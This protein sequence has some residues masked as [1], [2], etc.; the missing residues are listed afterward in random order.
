MKQRRFTV[1][2]L[3]CGIGG[4]DLGF[5]WAGFDVIW[6][7][8]IMPAAIDSYTANF[9]RQAVLSDINILPLDQ[10]PDADVLIGGPPCQSF[11]LVGQRR[12]GDT[13]GK[14]V[15]R[16]LEIVRIKRPQAFVMENVPGMAASRINGH[17][18]T[19]ILA[20][21]FEALGYTVTSMRLDASDYLVPQRRQRLFLVGVIGAQ[22]IRPDP[23]C[24][25]KEFYRIDV[26]TYDNGAKAAL[27]DLGPPVPKGHPAT[28]RSILPSAFAELMRR[29][30]G[31][32]F[33]LHETPRMS[34]TDKLLVSFIPPGGNYMNVP[35]KYA[36]QRILNFKKTGGRTTTYARLHPKRPSYTVNTY[37]RRPNVGSNFH[38]SKARLI[39]AREAM[40]LQSIP[41]HF[42]TIHTSQDAR[43]TL[44]GNAVPPLLA[45]AVA[46]AV[47]KALECRHGA[48]RFPQHWKSRAEK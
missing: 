36:T 32:E 30:G 44:I 40:R 29:K 43:N 42:T 31:Q 39:T 26:R 33:S 37:F 13:R 38:Y 45:Q 16:F 22:V 27:N 1:A 6:A 3:F 24:F 11:S 35:D 34:E 12:S 15:F 17:R 5:D 41:D 46:W 14:L 8:D 48:K 9:S 23:R 21:D 47:R 28:Y 10:I 20:K 4:L 2:S 25:A 7:S 18:L 19:D